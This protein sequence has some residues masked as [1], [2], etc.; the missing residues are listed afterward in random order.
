MTAIELRLAKRRRQFE[1]LF[2]T[3]VFQT[4]F[5]VSGRAPDVA[6]V[7]IT[8]DVV[9]VFSI[10]L[11]VVNVRAVRVTPVEDHRDFSAIKQRGVEAVGIPGIRFRQAKPEVGIGLFSAV[12]VKIEPYTAP[13]SD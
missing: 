12:A 9:R 11:C 1:M 3:L 10:V 6:R 7:I 5:V 8:G 2:L 13:G 4:E